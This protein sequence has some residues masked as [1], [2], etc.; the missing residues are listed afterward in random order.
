MPE[1]FPFFVSYNIE[2]QEE[3]A[4]NLTQYFEVVLRIFTRI[5]QQETHSGELTAFAGPPNLDSKG[6]PLKT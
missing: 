1:N 5:S 3:A 6:R 2:H 4:F